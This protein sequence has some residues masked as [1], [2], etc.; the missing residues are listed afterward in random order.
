MSFTVNKTPPY[1][2]IFRFCDPIVVGLF[3]AVAGILRWQTWPNEQFIGLIFAALVGSAVI[4]SSLSCY[5]NMPVLRLRDWIDRPLIGLLILLVMSLMTAYVFKISA[6][7][8]RGVIAMWMMGAAGGLVIPRI[9]CHA[10]IKNRLRRG[11]GREKIILIGEREQCHQFSESIK[12][13]LVLQVVAWV[14]SDYEGEN[15]EHAPTSM[16]PTEKMRMV[17]V[18]ALTDEVE[19]S[20]VERVVICGQLGDS[21][22]ITDALKLLMKTAVHVQY[23]P[24]YVMAPIF[25]LRMSDCAGRPVVDLSNSPLTD[26]Q[27]VV[28]WW[29]DK[30]ISCI[31]LI[32]ISPVL[33]ITALLVKLS[34][35]GPVFY[36]QDRH[37]LHGKTIRVLKFRTMFHGPLP[38]QRAALAEKMHIQTQVAPGETSGYYKGQKFQQA[39]RED[40]RITPIGKWLRN[41]SVD[42]LP[43]FINVLM[44]D[45][46]I[47][48][49]RP[50][51][52]AHNLSYVDNIAELMRRHYMKPGITGLA[53][54]SGARGETRSVEDMK[55]RIDYDLHYIQNWSLGL[56]MMI[57]LRTAL[58]GWVNKQP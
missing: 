38:P 46:S 11:I 53:Q 27:L 24:D 18:S 37:G 9:M 40:P 58:T 32:V 49:P 48:G 17:P 23:A 1:A 12:D 30:I 55:R 31:I 54:I 25:M 44:G 5:R 19:R 56:D 16:F 50:H 45:M 22:L 4:F 57:I 51:A 42:E 6:D 3:L 20:D 13:H 21:R 33:L 52:I 26:A 29:E 39:V 10:V 47:V 15:A 8:S 14:C 28:K 35:A 36:V 34:S 7:V 2:R 43:Q 41:T